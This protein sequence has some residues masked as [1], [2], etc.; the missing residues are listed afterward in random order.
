MGKARARWIT[1]TGVFLAILIV[2]QLATRPL[3][4]TFVTGSVNNML[5]ILAVML[6][7]LSSAAVI[8]AIS[9][10]FATMIGIGALWPFVP[11]IIAGNIVLVA[12]WHLI[13]FRQ[14]E[15]GRIREIA[16]H[17]PAGSGKARQI[18]ALV[19]AAAVKFAILYIGIAKLIVPVVLGFP[20]PKASAVSAAFSWPQI[21]TASI[22]GLVAMLLY[23]AL[24]RALPKK[25][26]P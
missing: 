21:V 20:E 7:G 9:P 18:I 22:G 5:L 15:Q 12:L 17:R 25:P 14:S 2:G 10:V 3:G 26:R 24:S 19:V 11:V 4:N 8:A 1:Q 16:A 23:P 13:A 6:C